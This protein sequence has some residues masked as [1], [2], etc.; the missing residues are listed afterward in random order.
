MYPR[1]KGHA[2]G[3]PH[4]PDRHSCNRSH[5]AARAVATYDDATLSQYGPKPWED[6]LIFF[7]VT[8]VTVLTTAESPGIRWGSAFQSASMQ[9]CGQGMP[10]APQRQAR[11]PVQGLSACCSHTHPLPRHLLHC[12]I[13]PLFPKPA[14]DNAEINGGRRYLGCKGAV[15]SEEEVRDG[16]VYY[17]V[18]G[19]TSIDLD[20]FAPLMKH[21]VEIPHLK[22]HGD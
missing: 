11:G 6:Q 3:T 13:L 7:P 1:L 17:R 19:R 5:H 22:G 16:V 20:A 8:C 18:N 15:F 10:A 21:E 12:V 2:V 9:H 14:M 4:I